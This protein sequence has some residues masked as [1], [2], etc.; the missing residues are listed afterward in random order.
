MLAS[1]VLVPEATMDEDHLPSTTEHDIWPSRQVPGMKPV[2]VAEP[3]KNS[4][5]GH[6]RFRIPSPDA[7]HQGA[8]LRAR[9]G[10]VVRH[11]RQPE[12]T[13]PT[14]APEGASC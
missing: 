9:W 14:V 13:G 7:R 1:L 5:N 10:I 8:S 12:F 6:F 3:V 2:P 11:L 4:A